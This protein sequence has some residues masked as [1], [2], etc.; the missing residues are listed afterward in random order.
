[1]AMPVGPRPHSMLG[2]CSHPDAAVHPRQTLRISI[3]FP[4][5]TCDS[6]WAA[7]RNGPFLGHCEPSN[8]P[9]QTPPATMATLFP[10]DRRRLFPAWDLHTVHGTPDRLAIAFAVQRVSAVPF[11]QCLQWTRYPH[12]KEVCGEDSPR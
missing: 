4:L 11:P 7:G 10:D 12:W 9:Q 8:T 6:A 2:Q 3:R 1:G 5:L